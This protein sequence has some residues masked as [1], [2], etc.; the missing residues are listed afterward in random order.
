MNSVVQS[1]NSSCSKSTEWVL[2]WQFEEILQIIAARPNSIQ[3]DPN[4]KKDND[5]SAVCLLWTLPDT[6]C[7]IFLLF[8]LR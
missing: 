3:F 1:S 7:Q 8:V 5:K 2:H 4:T 6:I